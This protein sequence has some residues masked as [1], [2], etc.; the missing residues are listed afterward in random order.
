MEGAES[1]IPN[2][3]LFRARGLLS[4]NTIPLKG[5]SIHEFGYCSST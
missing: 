4:T 5:G 1:G 3:R 2:A